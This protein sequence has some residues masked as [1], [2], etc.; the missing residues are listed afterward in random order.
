MFSLNN[1]ENKK[2]YVIPYNHNK[3][4]NEKVEINDIWNC[5]FFCEKL[6]YVTVDRNLR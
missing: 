5:I 1:L 2:L 3:D 4:S 6:F